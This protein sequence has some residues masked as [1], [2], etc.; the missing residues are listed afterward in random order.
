MRII[1]GRHRGT[2]LA[3]LAGDKTRP[4]S[5]RVRES[6]F[7]ILD[8]GRFGMATKD[9]IVVDLFAGTGALGLEALS[10]GATTANFV[11]NDAAALRVLRANI[12]RLK[13]T[14]DATVMA[15]NA[16]SLGAWRND[17]ATLVFADAPYGTGA[18]L[19]AVLNLHHIGGIAPEAV[20]VIETA[21]SEALPQDQLMAQGLQLADKRTY[22]KAALH[23]ITNS[24]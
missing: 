11:E 3:D 9:A 14:G 4:T 12:D 13:R 10:R 8:G 24:D 18:G 15:G 2:K 23:F 1:G 7:N 17:P 20:I 21:K 5:D 22:G 16:T 19:E 6:L